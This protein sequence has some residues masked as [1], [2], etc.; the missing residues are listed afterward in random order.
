M[1]RS[2]GLRSYLATKYGIPLFFVA[3]AVV[4]VLGGLRGGEFFPVFNWS[5]FSAVDRPG[6]T[7]E[8]EVTKIGN[9]AFDPPVAYFELPD[10]FPDVTRR[11]PTFVKALKA[12]VKLQQTD[13]SQANGR[14]WAME[15]GFLSIGQPV[16]YRIVSHLNEALER[17]KTGEIL[18]TY[19]WGEW[20]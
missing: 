5:L 18:D 2:S 16:E 19:V 8:L 10:I 11:G 17:R 3:Y 9:R 7:V 13:L 4:A 1:K 14:R 6:W 20:H 12:I 15:R